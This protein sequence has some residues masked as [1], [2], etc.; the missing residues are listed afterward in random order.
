MAAVT[1]GTITSVAS[2]GNSKGHRSKDRGK[3]KAITR[4]ACIIGIYSSRF[5][6]M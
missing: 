4:H 2:L 6:S 5:F 1:V 3:S